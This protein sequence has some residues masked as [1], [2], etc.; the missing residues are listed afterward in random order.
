LQAP[1]RFRYQTLVFGD[2]DIHLRTLKD[3]QQFLDPQGEAD[4]LGIS[5]ANW[6]L[7]GV[8]WD[9]SQVL[10]NFIADFDIAGKRILEVGCGMA[11]SSH[12]LNQRNADISATDY[13][14]ET[15]G[16]LRRNTT[17]ND[18]RAIPYT[19]TNW[20]DHDSGLG[21]FDLIIGSDILYEADHSAL[22]ADF[23][24]RHANATSE[25]LIVD[26]GRKQHARFSKRMV[27]CGYTHQQN[28]PETSDYLKKT[29]TGVILRY[30]R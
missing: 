22:L 20:A 29:F 2:R 1:L 19:R 10:A 26:P 5:S 13:H 30:N 15:E 11:L 3:T 7:F 12:L 6:A 17:L 28:T 8:V 9:S 4:A 23:I 25:V 18:G 24:D 16:F 14:P 27:K 21:R